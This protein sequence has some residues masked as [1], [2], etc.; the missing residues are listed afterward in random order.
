MASKRPQ[1]M[2]KR[3]RELAVKEKRDRKRA[4]KAELAIERADPNWV[5][6]SSI[7][8]PNEQYEPAADEA[9][10]S[11]PDSPAR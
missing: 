9:A 7:G 2:A 3:A 10:G 6:P 5:E 11:G 1:T 4:R 8:E